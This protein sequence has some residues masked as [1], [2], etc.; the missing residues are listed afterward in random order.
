M[1]WPEACCWIAFWLAVV[2]IF[3]GCQHMIE[4]GH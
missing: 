1:R 2:V 4:S 3:R